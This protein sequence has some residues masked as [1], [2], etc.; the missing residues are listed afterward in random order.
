[1]E[2]QVNPL[3]V[4]IP[5]FI[6]LITL[7]PPLS[8]MAQS[9]LGVIQNM[10]DQAHPPTVDISRFIPLITPL[11]PLSPMVQSRLE[12]SLKTWVFVGIKNIIHQLKKYLSW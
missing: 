7:L 8:P 10:E 11:P 6:P 12:V 4:A 3:T 5:R 1:M 9:Q 2:A